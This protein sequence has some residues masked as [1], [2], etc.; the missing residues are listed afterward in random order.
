MNKCPAQG[1]VRT[2]V[3]RPLEIRNGFI[4]AAFVSQQVAETAINNGK[5]RI[6]LGGNLQLAKRLAIG[7]ACKVPVRT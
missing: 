3:D 2:E 5:I 1:I 7:F 6:E 4:D